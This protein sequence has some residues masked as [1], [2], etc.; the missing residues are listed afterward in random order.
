[1]HLTLS[2]APSSGSPVVWRDIGG[3]SA[4]APERGKTKNRCE[5][6]SSS[7]SSNFAPPT[8]CGTAALGAESKQRRAKRAGARQKFVGCGERRSPRRQVH[9]SPLKGRGDS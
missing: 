4:I 5:E 6:R 9:N 7:R 1:M 2:L 8:Q 3:C